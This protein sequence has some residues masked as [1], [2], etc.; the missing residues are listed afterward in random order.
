MRKMGPDSAFSA[1]SDFAIDR[2]ENLAAVR[3][4]KAPGCFVREA[5]V[6]EDQWSEVVRPPL[7]S[8]RKTYASG[9]ETQRRGRLE[10][11]G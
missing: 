3:G 10:F 11:C 7:I 1:S 2:V 9:L 8:N 6:P 5:E 4:P